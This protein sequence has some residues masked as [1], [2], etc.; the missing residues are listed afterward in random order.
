LTGD[1]AVLPGITVLTVKM[2]KGQ[3]LYGTFGHGF[4]EL[5]PDGK[6]HG[7]IPPYGPVNQ[8]GLIA[9]LGI[10]M[11]RKC[12]VDDPEVLPAIDRAAKFFGYFVDKGSVPYGEHE[13]FTCHENNGK[14]ALSAVF[15]SAQ[16]DQPVAAHYYAQMATAAFKNREYGHTGQGFSYLWGALGANMGGPEAAAAFVKEALWHLDLVRRCDGSF[17]YDGGEQYGPGKTDDNTYYG[18]S[19]YNGLSP[20]ATYVLTYAIPLKKLCI[21]G[22][23]LKKTDWLSTKEVSQV[24]ASGHFDLERK[25]KTPQELVAA[26]TDWSPIVRSWAAEE[27]AM[28]PEA[29]PDYD[30]CESV[31]ME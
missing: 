6:L 10:V 8:A 7:S 18:K 11:G 25:Q 13:P 26:F 23:E 5:T 30:A 21:T 16:G 19:S 12:G 3:S 14:S 20:N 29:I 24:T 27:L 17:T 31:Y 1:K 28:R 2:A 9:N 22:R 4:S 15:F